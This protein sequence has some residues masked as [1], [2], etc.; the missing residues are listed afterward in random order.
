MGQDM[1]LHRNCSL[2]EE[3]G[4]RKS[5][6]LPGNRA[7]REAVWETANCPINNIS[8]FSSKELT[9]KLAFFFFFSA[10]DQLQ[11]CFIEKELENQIVFNFRKSGAARII[12][13]N[14]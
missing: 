9:P 8:T 11:H 14:D 13:L 12:I 4:E 1:S 2:R 7:N 3:R 10:E 6:L 5:Y